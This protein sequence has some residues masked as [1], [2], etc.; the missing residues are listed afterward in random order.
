MVFY[1]S[2]IGSIPA[3]SDTPE[4]SIHLYNIAGCHWIRRSHDVNFAVGIIVLVIIIGSKSSHWSSS[5]PIDPRDTIIPTPLSDGV[6]PL[7][8]HVVW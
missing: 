1:P 6:F 2:M 3:P 8:H 4:L 7:D 5:S